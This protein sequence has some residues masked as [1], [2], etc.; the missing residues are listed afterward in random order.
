MH[1]VY[2]IILPYTFQASLDFVRP[3]K[4]RVGME[5]RAAGSRTQNCIQHMIISQVQ[6][7]KKSP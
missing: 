6:D 5:T 4:L 3:P 7:G 2:N 1:G